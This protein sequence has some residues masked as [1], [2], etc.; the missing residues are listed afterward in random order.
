MF[1]VNTAACAE[2]S[3]RVYIIICGIIRAIAFKMHSKDSGRRPAI[4]I[5]VL[6]KR[7]MACLFIACF[8]VEFGH[9]AGFTLSN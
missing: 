6:A 7:L 2:S 8:H 4:T 1:I 9:A 5:P 3:D